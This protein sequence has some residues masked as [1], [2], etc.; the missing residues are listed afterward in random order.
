MTSSSKNRG[1]RM[2]TF[3]DAGPQP[4]YQRLEA[5]LSMDAGSTYNVGLSK[6]DFST[7]V[8]LIGSQRAS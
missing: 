5:F 1:D 2:K 7:K 6:S 8:R 3:K 4:L